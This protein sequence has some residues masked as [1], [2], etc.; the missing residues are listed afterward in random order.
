[1]HPFRPPTSSTRAE[2]PNL[3]QTQ[4]TSQHFF[5]LA[6]RGC[7]EPVAAGVTRW[8][9]R[10]PCLLVGSVCGLLWRTAGY[11]I[12]IDS[13]GFCLSD[14]MLDFGLP[15]LPIFFFLPGVWGIT[16]LFLVLFPR[17]SLKASICQ[18]RL[19]IIIIFFVCFARLRH[20]LKVSPPSLPPLPCSLFP[21]VFFF[22]VAHI[23]CVLQR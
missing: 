3:L 13:Q 20:A 2:H 1:M 15:P 8:W 18:T 19:F 4:A 17:G 6:R 5:F 14:G 21:D 16:R 9:A 11:A 12:D 7:P 22:L 10:P 23:Y